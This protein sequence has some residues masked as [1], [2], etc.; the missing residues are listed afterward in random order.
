MK[1]ILTDLDSLKAC[2]RPCVLAIGMFDGLHRGHLRVIETA[3]EI[4]GKNMPL[5]AS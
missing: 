1:S 5:H 4:A 3:S 2:K